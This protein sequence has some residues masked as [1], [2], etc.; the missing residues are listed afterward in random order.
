MEQQNNQAVWEE[1]L[2]YQRKEARHARLAAVVSV[3]LAAAVLIAVAVIVPRTLALIG[4]MESS[5]QE[6][7]TLVAGANRVVS[8]NAD[9]VSSA[10]EKMGEVDVNTLNEAIQDLSEVVKPLADFTARFR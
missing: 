7:D 1:M 2:A 4:H 10:I 6:I 8:D 3:I 5:L 9:A